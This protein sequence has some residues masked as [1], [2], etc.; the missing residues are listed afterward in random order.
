MAKPPRKHHF[1]QAEHIRQFTDSRGLVTVYGKDGS[2]F[3]DKPQGIFKKK[4]LNSFRLEGELDTS[5][6]NLATEIENEC[7]P[8][9]RK[10][11]ESQNVR[12]EDTDHI[13]TYMAFSRLR[14]PNVQ[15]G[16][17]EIHRQAVE[18][19]ARMMDRMG[20]FDDLGPNPLD[21]KKSISDL[22]DDGTVF[23]D[24]NNAVYLDAIGKTIEPMFK[25]MANAYHWC[26]I[27]SPQKRV[28]I[29]DHPL[30]YVHPGMDPGPYGISP[31][32]KDCEIA[33]PLSSELYL[34]GKWETQ[35]ED[36]V[37][38]D[39]VDELNK[40]QAMFATRHLA[41]WQNHRRWYSLVKRYKDFAFQTRTETLDVGEGAYQTIRSG[42]LRN[43]SS[44]NLKLSNPLTKTQAILLPDK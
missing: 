7:W 25:L 23:I 21:R 6:E 20:K 8:T 3:Q 39:A 35:I 43:L 33:F 2:R 5:F 40:R 17:V 44:D 16:I 28:V 37:S 18:Q 11:I 26:L 36:F 22:L 41:H 24:V 32:G 15:L 10:I 9:I 12:P 27:K 19:V 14:N 13:A 4:D 34:F 29:G 31:G 42:V 30:T 1:V 38:E